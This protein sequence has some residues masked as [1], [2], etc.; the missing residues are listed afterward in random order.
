M[1]IPSHKIYAS[2]GSTLIYTIANVIKREPPIA[3][4][5]P[6]EIELSNLRGSG[7]I[8]ISGGNQ[9]YDIIIEMRL[10]G[11]D[12]TE[13][14]SALA[15]LK[16]SIVVK[17]NY[18]LKYDKTLITNESLESIKVRLKSLVPDTSR[19]NLTKFCYVTLT[20]RALSW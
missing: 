11:A 16:S 3:I 20:F 9:P 13:V 4:D 5:V 18:Y 1:A 19:G 7:A 6:S 15:T 12:Y 10:S 14:M 2:N 8:T 17:T